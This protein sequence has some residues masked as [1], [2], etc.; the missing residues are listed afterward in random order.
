M[1]NNKPKPSE[2]SHTKNST[3]RRQSHEFITSGSRAQLSYVLYCCCCCQKRLVCMY[4]TEY[5][6]YKHMSMW[7][8]YV[9][10]CLWVCMQSD[11]PIKYGGTVVLL[12]GLF[13]TMVYILAGR[14]QGRRAPPLHADHAV[15][16]CISTWTAG[17]CEWLVCVR[18]TA[19]FLLF[20]TPFVCV[21]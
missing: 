21:A 18:R 20:R 1:I 10:V 8:L 2:T 9:Y 6:V 13:G 4:A 14:R 12:F 15:T 11:A 16:S 17:W 5:C 7:C 19:A 3:Q